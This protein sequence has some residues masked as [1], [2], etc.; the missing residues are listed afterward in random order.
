MEELFAKIAVCL[1]VIGS[2][3][4]IVSLLMRFGVIPQ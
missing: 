3:L 2:V 1:A 4:S